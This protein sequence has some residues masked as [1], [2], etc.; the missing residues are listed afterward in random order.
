MTKRS[1]RTIVSLGT[2]IALLLSTLGCTSSCDENSTIIAP[3]ASPATTGATIA[4]RSWATPLDKPGLKNLHR[5]NDN[6]YRGAQ[7]KADGMKQLRTMG[8][9]TVV[10]LRSSNPDP[11]LVNDLPLDLVWIKTK[12]TRGGINEDD[13]VEF[14]KIACDPNRGPVF[15]HCRLGSDRTGVMCAMY[16]IVVEGWGKEEAIDEMRK[17][18]FGFNRL[19]IN[20]KTFIRESDVENIRKRLTDKAG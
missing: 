4:Q 3:T 7:P 2:L 20:L 18:G 17:G 11:D 5:I 12:A 8:V 16:R 9:K 15:V 13:V 1:H 19:F 10:N 6:L 14:L